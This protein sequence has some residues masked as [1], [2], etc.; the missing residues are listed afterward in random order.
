MPSR[1]TV[2]SKYGFKTAGK[3]Q[4]VIRFRQIST[5]ARRKVNFHLK[6]S[7][8]ST[9]TKTGRLDIIRFFWPTNLQ[10]IK[11]NVVW[12][13]H[14]PTNCTQPKPEFYQN[15]DSNQPENHKRLYNLDSLCIWGYTQILY[16]LFCKVSIGKV[17]NSDDHHGWYLDTGAY[18]WAAVLRPQNTFRGHIKQKYDAVILRSFIIIE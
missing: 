9:Q 16:V 2:F 18:K 7:L 14:E 15:M 8:G 5:L 10:I 17:R 11:A 6:Y 3:S 4:E 1:N 12:N 13:L